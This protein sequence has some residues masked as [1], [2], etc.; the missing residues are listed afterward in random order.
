MR[1]V[2][3]SHL[4][5]LLFV[6]LTT[7]AIAAPVSDQA[8]INALEATQTGFRLVHTKV[9]PSVVFITS[10]MVEQGRASGSGVIIDPAGIVLTNRHVVDNA[11]KLTVQLANS[12]KLL[13]AEVVQMDE[14]TDLAIVRITEKGTYP[15]ATLGDASKVQVGDWGIA[16][17]AP[18]R[19]SQTMTVG[20]ISATGR[21]LRAPGDQYTYRDLLQTDASINPG[22]S[23]GP[24][25]NLNG[26]VIGV[27]FMIFSP[28]DT[29]GSV[30]IGFAIPINDETKQIIRTLSAGRAY[31]RGRLGIVVKNLDNV[32]RESY[33]VPEGGILVDSVVAGQAGDKAGLQAEDVILSVDN[34][35]ITDVDQFIALIQRTTP[36]TKVTLTLMRD[37]KEVKVPVTVG[38][39]TPTT[40][41]NVVNERKLGMSVMAVTPEVA[42]QYGLP[43]T[44]GVVVTIVAPGSP[45]AEAGFEPG[46]VI[47]RV[48]KDEVSTPDEFWQALAKNMTE[49]KVG[50]L[51]RVRRG[52]FGTTLGLPKL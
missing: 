2:R 31:E 12:D 36:G 9:A 15:A 50:A 37:G 21:K 4:C 25:V 26:E 13:P 30:G 24:L 23:G 29:A 5:A 43:V 17:G 32:M 40:T 45:A 51:L 22:N 14:Q 7:V 33:K 42:R 35:K 46:D 39:A 47:Q 41:A 49:S 18:F 1:S 10:Q 48:G 11:T 3:L 34:T 8:A 52:Q 28:G 16:F 44:S 6:A 27:N 20:V 19:L 38:T